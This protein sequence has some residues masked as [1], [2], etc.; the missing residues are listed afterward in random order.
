MVW[1]S[2]FCVLVAISLFITNIVLLSKN[3]VMDD[4]HSSLK[5]Q[6]ASIWSVGGVGILFSGIAIWLY[7]NS[8][9]SLP[10]TII[11]SLVLSSFA[12]FISYSAMAAAVIVKKTG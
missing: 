1:G 3:G 10:P 6:L 7:Y 11:I 4:Q 5:G 2:G 12:I 8:E 9:N